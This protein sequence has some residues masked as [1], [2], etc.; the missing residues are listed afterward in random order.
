MLK[1]NLLPWREQARQAQQRQFICWLAVSIIIAIMVI[2]FW[3]YHFNRLIN[4]QTI[5][6]ITLHRDLQSLHYKTALL[7][8]LRQRQQHLQARLKSL[9]T[10]TAQRKQV[11]LLYET[12]ASA[13]PPM[14]YITVIKKTRSTIFIRGKTKAAKNIIALL[15]NISHM[16]Q[17]AVPRLINLHYTHADPEF[18]LQFTISLQALTTRV[19]ICS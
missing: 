9:H 6:N 19:H 3:Q 18:H 7:R 13:M 11:T 2:I 16:T 5:L 14:T 17:F 12:L 1:L 10:L 4:N 8:Q 15:R